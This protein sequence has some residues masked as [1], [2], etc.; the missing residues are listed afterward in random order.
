M[1]GTSPPVE[2]NGVPVMAVAAIAGFDYTFAKDDSIFLGIGVSCGVANL[3]GTSPSVAVVAQGT[4][5]GQSPFTGTVDTAL[6]VLTAEQAG[7]AVDVVSDAT[8]GA[9][10]NPTIGPYL[11][12]A[13]LGSAAFFLQSFF[14]QF[15]IQ[16]GYETLLTQLQMGAPAAGV[17]LNYN[18]EVGQARNGRWG[19]RRTG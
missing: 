16:S 2:L 17:K 9:T 18:G 1:G 13:P 8:L 10:N 3:F 11:G 15:S 7:V 6:L 14:A 4:L 12:G 5:T 19:R